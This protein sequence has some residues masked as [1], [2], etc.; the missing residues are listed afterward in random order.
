MLQLRQFIP[1]LFCGRRAERQSRNTPQKGLRL[2]LAS[3]A[4]ADRATASA[5]GLAQLV[6]GVLRPPLRS[7]GRAAL[8]ARRCDPGPGRAAAGHPVGGP[9]QEPQRGRCCPPWAASGGWLGRH[10]FALTWAGQRVRPLD[11]ARPEALSPFGARLAPMASSS[12]LPSCGAWTAR[13]CGAHIA[14]GRICG[15]TT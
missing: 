8:N 11:E 5:S 2:P 1:V 12:P 6:K 13:P 10:P 15:A 14:A 9:P 7:P 3:C 4:R